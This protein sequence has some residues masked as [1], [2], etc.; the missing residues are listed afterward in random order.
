MTIFFA[1]FRT[2]LVDW[3]VE[4]EWV[5]DI[6]IVINQTVGYSE[7]T[8]LV[9]GGGGVG[10][11]ASVIAETIVLV[12]GLF[13]HGPYFLLDFIIA[14]DI[15]FGQRLLDLAQERVAHLALHR[16]GGGGDDGEQVEEFHFLIS[17]LLIKVKLIIIIVEDKKE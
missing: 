13:A 16:I 3:L 1:Q 12:L 14:S 2:D 15:L 7:Y 8:Y 4:T 6:L 10:S 9:H 11:Q 17:K 5:D